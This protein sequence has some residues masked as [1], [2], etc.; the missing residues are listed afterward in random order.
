M[1]DVLS[2]HLR[3][4]KAMG[5]DPSN[6]FV[7]SFIELKMD[8]LTMFEWQ[9][10]SQGFKAVPHYQKLL[11]FLDLRA[12]AS[13]GVTQKEQKR[14]QPI[15]SKGASSAKRERKQLVYELFTAWT[16]PEKMSF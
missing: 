6:S 16:L 10:H 13:E 14:P 8:R 15:V 4:L 9:K 7:T 2:Q 1:H 5:E 12:Q 3:A 11:D